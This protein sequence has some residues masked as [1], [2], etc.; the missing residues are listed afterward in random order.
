VF[1]RFTIP[2]LPGPKI[3]TKTLPSSNTLLNVNERFASRLISI[4]DFS[5]FV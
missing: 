5:V 3:G 1:P 4:V 2:V